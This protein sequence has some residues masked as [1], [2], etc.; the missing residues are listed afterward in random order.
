MKQ[1]H[2]EQIFAK[3]HRISKIKG[4]TF[5]AKHS[6]VLS[7]PKYLKNKSRH[8]INQNTAGFSCIMHLVVYSPS[9]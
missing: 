1:K 8:F 5:L 6:H 9:H 4:E 3:L 7:N 2:M